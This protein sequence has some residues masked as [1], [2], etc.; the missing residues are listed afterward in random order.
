MF[1]FALFLPNMRAV[2]TV[3]RTEFEGKDDVK[4]M[5]GELT[6][7]FKIAEDVYMLSPRPGKLFDLLS[8]LRENKISYRTHF[9]SVQSKRF[10]D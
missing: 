9:D 3:F 4:L 1:S 10:T 6:D 7:D 5:V 8:I 2:I